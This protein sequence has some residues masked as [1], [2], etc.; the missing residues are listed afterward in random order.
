[1]KKI[2]VASFA[3]CCA[4]FGAWVLATTPPHS[5]EAP[6]PDQV[7]AVQVP[8]D[9]AVALP[10]TGLM[11]APSDGAMTPVPGLERDSRVALSC[12]AT[13]ECPCGDTISCTGSWDCYAQN[14][15][16]VKCDGHQTNCYWHYCTTYLLCGGFQEISC[17]GT[18]DSC[19]SGSDWIMCNGEVYTC[20]DCA[21]PQIRCSF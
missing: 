2:I 15:K 16:Y 17:S 8:G 4:A 12:T 14:R 9:S 10:D 3:L 6:T 5:Q 7:T 13:T 1:M 19:Q 11:V 20:D 18:C 21:F